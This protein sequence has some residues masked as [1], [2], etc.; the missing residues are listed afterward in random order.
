MTMPTLETEK[1]EKNVEMVNRLG[2]VAVLLG[3]RSGAHA[4]DPLKKPL[5]DLEGF[6]RVFISLHG[7]FGEDGCVQGGVGSAI[8]EFM[9]LGKPVIATE[10][11]NVYFL[12]GVKEDKS[13]S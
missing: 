2:K 10:L 8:L 4:F 3:G 1:L 13:I 9:A 5:H 11:C 6:D 7:R 12:F